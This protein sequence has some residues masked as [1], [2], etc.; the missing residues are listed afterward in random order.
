MKVISFEKI[1]SLNISPLTCYEWA[2]KALREKEK[3]LLPAKISLK[4]SNKE[5][6]FYNTMPIIMEK[7]AGLKEVTR[8]P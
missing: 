8:Y 6:V 5:G 3:A 1:T 2:D 7:W 4:P